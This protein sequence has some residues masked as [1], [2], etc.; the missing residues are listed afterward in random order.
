MTLYVIVCY[1][2]VTISL[3]ITSS[4]FVNQMTGFWCCSQ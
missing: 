3:V 1:I 2:A 4:F